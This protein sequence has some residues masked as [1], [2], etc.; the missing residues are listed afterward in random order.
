MVQDASVNL[1]PRETKA[2]KLGTHDNL[3]QH[4][5][6]KKDLKDPMIKRVRAEFIFEIILR[7][8]EEQEDNVVDVE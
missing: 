5:F 2:I 8:I 6:S 4:T 3:A 7:F 1:A